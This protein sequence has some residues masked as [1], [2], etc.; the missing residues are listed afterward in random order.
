MFAEFRH[1]LRRMRGQMIGWGIGIGLYS[2][3]MVSLYSTIAGIEGL[4]ELMESYPPEILAFFGGE[5]A[6]NTPEG[7]LNMEY[8]TF[9]T[10]IIGIFAVGAGAGLLAADE[11]KGILDLV[12]AHPISRTALF[13]GR[14]LGFVA[15][16]GVI[17]LVGW[18]GLLIPSG[19]SGM[20][21]TWIEFL[22]PFLSLYAELLLFGAL[23]L[24]LSMVL[25]SVRMASMLAGGLLVGNFLL[26]GLSNM[27]EDLKAIVEF[28]P[29]Y[30]YQGGGA[31][32]GLNW[33]WVAGLLAVAPLFALVA[34]WRFQR[35]DIR[36]GG[37]HS[38]QLPSLAGLLRRS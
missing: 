6:F 20:E 37:E 33:E 23:A 12:I 15:A 35:R 5:L 38:W 27:N 19:S 7:Y 16:T 32:A 29:L 10:I 18:L 4:K 1:T 14:L 30:Y 9:M 25:P 3:L 28:T 31:I 36:V 8:F 13:W 2:L 21:L 34:W 11:E 26:L 22:R 17:L 24:L